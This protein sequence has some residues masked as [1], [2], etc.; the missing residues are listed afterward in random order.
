MNLDKVI[1]ISVTYEGKEQHTHTHTEAGRETWRGRGAS[2][3][4]RKTV[5]NFQVG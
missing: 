3:K 5:V 4:S 2:F 1:I